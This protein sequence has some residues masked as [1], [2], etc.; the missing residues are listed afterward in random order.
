MEHYIQRLKKKSMVLAHKNH[1][2]ESSIHVATGKKPTGKAASRVSPTVRVYAV[3]G[4]AEQQRQ[5]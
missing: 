5:E 2:V 4:K 1:T 3:L